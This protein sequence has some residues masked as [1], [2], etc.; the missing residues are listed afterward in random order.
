MPT[1]TKRPCRQRGADVGQ[2]AHKRDRVTTLQASNV[3]AWTL[4]RQN[5]NRHGTSRS[6][7]AVT[8]NTIRICSTLVEKAAHFH[9][10]TGVPITFS[11]PWSVIAYFQSSSPSPLANTKWHTSRFNADLSLWETSL[12]AHT[13]PATRAVVMLAVVTKQSHDRR[14]MSICVQNWR[15]ALSPSHCSQQVFL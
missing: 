3:T 8:E 14:S 10:F 6:L 7:K 15:T 4:V 13:K 5:T 12:N 2:E 1:H 11:T 9:A